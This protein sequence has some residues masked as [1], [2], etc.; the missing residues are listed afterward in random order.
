MSTSEWYLVYPWRHWPDYYTVDPLTNITD[1][2]HQK[3]VLGG[4]SCAWSSSIDG[5]N[6]FFMVWPKT[7][8]AAER[9]WSYD[10]CSEDNSVEK[11]IPRLSWFRC[12][13]LER[14]IESNGLYADAGPN[15]GTSCYAS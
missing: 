12:L 1:P 14:G 3:R 8:A 13:L 10:V 4:E 9:L 2:Q 11:A 15:F 7:A 6:L 5:G